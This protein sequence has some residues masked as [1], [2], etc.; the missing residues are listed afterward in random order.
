MWRCVPRVALF[1]ARARA[2][3]VANA[4]EQRIVYYCFGPGAELPAVRPPAVARAGRAA[5]GAASPAPG[6]AVAVSPP[7]SESAPESPL[8]AQLAAWLRAV[9]LQHAPDK[10][11]N[12]PQVLLKYRGRERELVLF[13]AAKY[14]ATP[15]PALAGGSGDERA[16][17][18]DAPAGAPTRRP[19]G[20]PAQ[21]QPSWSE[22][23]PA[24]LLRVVGDALDIERYVAPGV[25]V[26]D[27]TRSR[28]WL[29][30]REACD[31]EWQAKLPRWCQRHA[32]L[33]RR[34]PGAGVVA[35]VQSTSEL[36]RYRER[37]PT[38][39]VAAAVVTRSFV[40]LFVRGDSVV[41]VRRAPPPP[42]TPPG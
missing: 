8:A 26:V 41:W 32:A 35:A 6:D 15:P 37:H 30:A 13:V 3:V 2:Q 36:R 31:R 20:A 4:V 42:P 5:A 24:W 29:A 23:R 22:A 25:P 7:A 38:H 12:V 34:I 9:M 10:V 21:P 28:G 39:A 16:A 19:A 18:A 14:G 33:R 27:A 1:T 40:Q 11:G 17:R